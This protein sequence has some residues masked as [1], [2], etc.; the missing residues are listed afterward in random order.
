[1]N[2]ELQKHRALA[3]K[4]MQSHIF[5]RKNWNFGSN[6]LCYDEKL[7]NY[8]SA[9]V[10]GVCKDGQLRIEMELNDVQYHRFVNRSD[11]CVLPRPSDVY[12]VLTNGWYKFHDQY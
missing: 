1:M 6:L 3:V 2:H 7:R 12:A 11:F 9:K 10:V 4:T 5:I 8:V